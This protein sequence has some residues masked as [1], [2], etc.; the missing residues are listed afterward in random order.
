[1][2]YDLPIQPSVLA[3]SLYH[4]IKYREDSEKSRDFYTDTIVLKMLRDTVEVLKDMIE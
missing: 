1:M 4:A 3:D 2:I